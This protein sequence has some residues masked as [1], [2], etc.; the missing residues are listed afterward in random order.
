MGASSFDFTQDE[1][2]LINRTDVEL[3]IHTFHFEA[4]AHSIKIAINQDAS[5][6]KKVYLAVYRQDTIPPHV[7][8]EREC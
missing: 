3:V 7:A 5:N 8:S 6:F 1:R 4:S 2:F